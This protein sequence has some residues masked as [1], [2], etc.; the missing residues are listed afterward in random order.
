MQRLMCF[1]LLLGLL[2]ACSTARSEPSPVSIPPTE[3]GET[4]SPKPEDEPI[5]FGVV[6]FD[7]NECTV[8]GPEEI[9]KGIYY[10]TLNDKSD[11]NIQ[12]W[13]NQILEDKTFEDLLN[14][15]DEPGVYRAPPD[16]IEHPRST[17]LAKAGRRVHYLDNVGNYATLVGGLNPASLWFCEPFRVVEVA[18]E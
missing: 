11:K 8:E 4:P 18:E 6:T 5:L 2:A 12:L 14:W 9:S 17:F 7:G 15:Q 10:F 3:T 13:V 1:M 16:W